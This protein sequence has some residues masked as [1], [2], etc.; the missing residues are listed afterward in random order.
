MIYLFA[1]APFWKYDVT[2]AQILLTEFLLN[3]KN[4]YSVSEAVHLSNRK[5]GEYDTESGKLFHDP[6]GWAAIHLYGNPNVYL[7]KSI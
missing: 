3:F 2:M 1:N 5:V 4:G 7:K 6:A